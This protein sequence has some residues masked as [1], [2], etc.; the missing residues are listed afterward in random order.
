MLLIPMIM[1]CEDR[2]I[3]TEDNY[4]DIFEATYDVWFESNFNVNCNKW[5]SALRELGTCRYNFQLFVLSLHGVRTSLRALAQ[6]ERDRLFTITIR[7]HYEVDLN[8]MWP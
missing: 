3:L 7:Q 4:L 1:G 2:L 6:S 5:D 8:K